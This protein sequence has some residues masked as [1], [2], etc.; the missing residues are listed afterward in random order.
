[1]LITQ[2]LPLLFTQMC[3][4]FFLCIVYIHT[5]V[6]EPFKGKL[7][8]SQPFILRFLSVHFLRTEIFSYISTV[9]LSASVNLTWMPHCY[10][11]YYL[12]SNSALDPIMSFTA[13]ISFPSEI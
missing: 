11:V 1:M 12:Y 9:Q 13:F 3:L 4:W 5:H 2:F 7:H 6:S 8:T 10:L